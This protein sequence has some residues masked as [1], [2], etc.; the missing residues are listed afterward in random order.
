MIIIPLI[1]ISVSWVQIQII[2][3]ASLATKGLFQQAGQWDATDMLSA[4]SWTFGALC[5]PFL[6]LSDSLEFRHQF[7]GQKDK[8]STLGIAEKYAASMMNPEFLKS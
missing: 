4:A 2:I 7:C 8:G 5:L 6:S 1:F 3:F